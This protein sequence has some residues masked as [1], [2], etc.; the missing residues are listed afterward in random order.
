[1][2][3][4]RLAVPS[5][6]GRDLWKKKSLTRALLHDE[7]V[8][9]DFN[10]G[11]VVD[12]LAWCQHRDFDVEVWQLVRSHRPKPGILVAHRGREMSHRFSEGLVRT[13]RAKTAPQFVA[14][15]QRHENS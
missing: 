2:R 4:K 12:P 14:P 8:T 10:L 6:F 13:E 1:M 11:D 7:A 9:P 5:A 15:T 3:Q